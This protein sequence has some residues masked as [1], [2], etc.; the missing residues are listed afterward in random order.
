MDQE[1]ITL[2]NAASSQDLQIMMPASQQLMRL[3]EAASSAD[4]SSDQCISQFY[5]R[6]TRVLVSGSFDDQLQGGSDL[7]LDGRLIGFIYLKNTISES[8]VWTSL[9]TDQRATIKSLLLDY[10]SRGSDSER[11]CNRVELVPR[12]SACVTDLISRL[13]KAE[14][15]KGQWPDEAWKYMA[16]DWCAYLTLHRCL[17]AASSFCLALRRKQLAKVIEELIMPQLLTQWQAVM[18]HQANT[19]SCVRLTQVLTTCFRVLH[20]RRHY[21]KPNFGCIEKELWLFREIL[22]RS[23]ETLNAI[24]NTS[25]GLSIVK[26]SLGHLARKLSKLVAVITSYCALGACAGQQESAGR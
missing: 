6:L 9:D 4:A 5:S 12:L 17:R 16:S 1:L 24:A 21:N 2:L 7:S 19:Q 15:P 25:D 18:S 10:L 26:F 23:F 13:V 22:Q 3:T 11:F 14:W 8:K 20:H